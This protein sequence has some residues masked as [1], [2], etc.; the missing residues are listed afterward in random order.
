M[1]HSPNQRVAWLLPAPPE[2]SQPRLL[3]IHDETKSSPRYRG[4][5]VVFSPSKTYLGG[6]WKHGASRW[7]G[8]HCAG[9]LELGPM[10]APSQT[11]QVTS[12]G[13]SLPLGLRLLAYERDM[14]TTPSTQ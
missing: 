2:S 8:G 4:G 1:Q 9:S 6:S 10:Q 3:L 11:R 14:K 13:R 7:R 5:L 12:A